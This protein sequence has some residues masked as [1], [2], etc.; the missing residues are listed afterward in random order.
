MVKN[1]RSIGSDK[2]NIIENL[3]LRR[4][5]ALD[6]SHWEE[7]V[8]NIWSYQ[9]IYDVHYPNQPKPQQ[10]FRSGR[11]GRVHALI[12]TNQ[13]NKTKRGEEKR[14][15]RKRM[16]DLNLAITREVDQVYPAKEWGVMEGDGRRA[17][18]SSLAIRRT[19][20]QAPQLSGDV[21]WMTG[22]L[23][24]PQPH[25]HLSAV[26]ATTV[27]QRVERRKMVLGECG[28]ID[29]TSGGCGWRR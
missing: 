2:N 11:L 8:Q 10:H 21:N 26:R 27:A 14:G 3:L 18:T 9:F 17:K 7:P 15:K 13:R 5:S 16:P 1:Q 12:H 4:T 22:Q 25:G 24:M 28:H 19:A 6:I 20:L 23:P 29:N